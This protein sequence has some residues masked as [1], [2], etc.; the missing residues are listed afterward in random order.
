VPEKIAVAQSISAY[1]EEA[2]PERISLLSLIRVP[3]MASAS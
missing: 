1:E 3:E 2:V